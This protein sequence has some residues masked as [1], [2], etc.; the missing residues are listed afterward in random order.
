MLGIILPHVNPDGYR[1]AR[2]QP[3]HNT[4]LGMGTQLVLPPL[5]RPPAGDPELALRSVHQP[6]QLWRRHRLQAQPIS[7]LQH[8]QL[9]L[10]NSLLLLAQAAVSVEGDVQLLEP[11]PARGT[12]TA[13]IAGRRHV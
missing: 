1:L 7:Q 9:V 13:R 11:S 8:Y 5:Q 4:P 3:S 12:D 10:G 6:L 2:G